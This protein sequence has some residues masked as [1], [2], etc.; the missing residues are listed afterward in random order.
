MLLM[1]LFREMGCGAQ[2]YLHTSECWG[3]LGRGACTTVSLS[4]GRGTG[5]ERTLLEKAGVLF[6]VHWEGDK[7]TIRQEGTE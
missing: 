4:F 1:I 7:Q 5:S 2:T 3:P 6:G